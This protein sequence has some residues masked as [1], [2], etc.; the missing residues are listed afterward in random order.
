MTRKS[1]LP[2]ALPYQLSFSLSQ[3]SW[4]GISLRNLHIGKE[5]QVYIIFARK[6]FEHETFDLARNRNHFLANSLALIP[7]LL[8]HA[9]STQT[10]RCL[11]ISP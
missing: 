4:G 1:D 6:E 11:R 5:A 8:E 7:T 9:I 3:C 2:L 10:A